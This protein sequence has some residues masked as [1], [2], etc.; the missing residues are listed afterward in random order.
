[1]T[2]MQSVKALS[3]ALIVILSPAWMPSS[4]AH[5]Q[6]PGNPQIEVEDLDESETLAVEVQAPSVDQTEIQNLFDEA[7]SVFH[8]EDRPASLTLF[9]HVVGI[10]SAGRDTTGLDA[11][12][13]NLLVRSY[14]YRSWV[15]HELGLADRVE[16]ELQQILQI[17]PGADLASLDSTLPVPEDLLKLFER[18]QKKTVGQVNFVL[19]PYDAQ[20]F[21]DD[22]AVESTDQ[23]VSVL[24]TPHQVRIERPGYAP[25]QRDLEVEAGRSV[26]LEL[27]LERQSA[28][29][30]LNTRPRGAEIRIDGRS[31]G[32]TQGTAAEG[33]LPQGAAALYRREEFSDEMIVEGLEPG[34]RILEIAKDGHRPYRMELVIQELID[35][36]MPPIVLEE[37]GGQLVFVDFPRGGEIRING[38]PAQPD[39]P[40]VSRPKVSLDPGDYHVTVIDGYSK[41]FSTRLN[42]ADRQNVEVRVELKPG[43]SFL[44]VL[45]GD[46][47]AAQNLRQ[48]F[49]VAMKASDKWTLI[50]RSPE[51]PGVLR[52][53]GVDAA[54]LREEREVEWAKIQRAVDQK[55]PG[56]LYILAVLD[57]DLVATE[58]DLWIFAAGPGPSKPD[59]VTI[60][61]S[62]DP[63]LEDLRRRLDESLVLRRPYTGMVTIDSN[64]TPHP[65]VADVTPAGPA[66]AANLRPGDEIV[67]I[68]GIPIQSR[69]ELESRL[70]AAESG[71]TLELVVRSR[72]VGRNERIELGSSPRLLE[73]SEGYL[74]SV[75]YTD[76]VLLEE[77]IR[78][79]DELWIVQLN[80]AILMMES[81]ELEAAAKLLRTIRGPQLSHGVSQGTVD[82]FL[83]LALSRSGAAELQNAARQAFERAARLP[84]ARLR[85]NDEAFLLP[86][87]RA[88]LHELS[89]GGS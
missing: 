9:G 69:K 29:L 74:P 46:Q 82:Y 78:N 22:Q 24:A 41:M 15:H 61:L 56:L 66:E 77:R 73:P 3:F 40:G 57:N 16:E 35:Y 18:Q 63:A 68:G 26:T 62:S 48:S 51:G 71:E 13:R 81:G 67:G 8:G 60:P 65:V 44:G 1:M 17:D 47:T 11:E 50:D 10:L 21:I 83:G 43:L 20:V 34:L 79:A 54:G 84:G 38:K 53:I 42:L 39:V 52:G 2:A 70:S 85:H 28:I 55:A 72:G 5:G 6:L 58:A 36:Q 87:V 25:I 75:A 31:F 14:G 89:A 12:N 7:L 49:G 64:A 86:R 32:F 19:D 76:L 33:F 45:G 80:R 27:T 88:R 30:R 4:A 23:P 37:Q 59:R